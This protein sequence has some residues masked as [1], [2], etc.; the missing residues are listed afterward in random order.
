MLL[1][2][3]YKLT[4]YPIYDAIYFN[5]SYIA[6]CGRERGGKPRKLSLLTCGFNTVVTH[7]GCRGVG[8]AGFKD[9]IRC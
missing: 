5:Y 4:Y 7:G 2:F 9:D 3:M 6:M 8:K 1:N